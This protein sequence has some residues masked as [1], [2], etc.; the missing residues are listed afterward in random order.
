[1]HAQKIPVAEATSFAV[2]TGIDIGLAA[3]DAAQIKQTLLHAVREYQVDPSDVYELAE[4]LI[5][6]FKSLDNEVFVRTEM[7]RE[8]LKRQAERDRLTLETK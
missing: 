1:M 3:G 6:S 7:E 2:E 8:E 4:H 5:A